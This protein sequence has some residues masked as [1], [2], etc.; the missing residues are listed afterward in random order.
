M[1]RAVKTLPPQYELYRTLDLTKNRLVT[2]GVNLVAVAFFFLFGWLVLLFLTIARTDTAAIVAKI[3][4][5]FDTISTVAA[6]AVLIGLQIVMVVLHE[7]AHGTFFWVFTRERPVF[8]LKSLHAAYAAAP[9]WYLPRNQHLIVGAAS[10]VLI[11]LAGL[12]L[13]P[14]VPPTMVPALLFVI[15]SNGAGAVGDFMMIA[16]LLGQ[17]KETLVRD[18]GSAITIYRPT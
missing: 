14:I 11:T 13:L 2:T 17:P 8:G 4:S 5:R 15:V 12:T 3:G 6:I 18:T 10:F 9:D 16:Y 1:P 7:L